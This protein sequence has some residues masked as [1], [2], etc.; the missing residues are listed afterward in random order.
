MYMG[1]FGVCVILSVLGRSFTDILPPY[2]CLRV[3][4]KSLMISIKSAE[5]TPK[6]NTTQQ[7]MNRVYTIGDELCIN[8]T[9]NLERVPLIAQCIIAH[10]NIRAWTTWLYPGEISSSIKQPKNTGAITMRRKIAT[11][12]PKVTVSTRRVS[13]L[14]RSRIT[15]GIGYQTKSVDYVSLTPNLFTVQYW[16]SKSQW[17]HMA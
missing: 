10:M 17:Y 5:S 12:F 4:E 15:S 3:S 9:G 8:Y 7:C 16:H 2:D 1:C 11:R 14:I 6:Q 13:V